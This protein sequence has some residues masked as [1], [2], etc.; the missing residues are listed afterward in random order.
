M[1]LTLGGLFLMGSKGLPG[2]AAPSPASGH[3]L[4]PA[5]GDGRRRSRR[6]M[7]RDIFREMRRFK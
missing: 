1:A 7:A 6:E 2:Q 3:T 4:P 5:A